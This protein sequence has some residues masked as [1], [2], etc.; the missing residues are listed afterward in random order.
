MKF[1]ANALTKIC[2]P[3]SYIDTVKP[4]GKLKQLAEENKGVPHLDLFHKRTEII[5]IFGSR[6]G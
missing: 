2:S 6:V 3:S 1:S 5:I 4:S